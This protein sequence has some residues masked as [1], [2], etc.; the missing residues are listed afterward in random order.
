[1]LLAASFITL[2]IYSFFFF[3]FQLQPMGHLQGQGLYIRSDVLEVSLYRHCSP[4]CQRFC[5]P[6]SLH[7]QRI[8]RAIIM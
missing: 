7:Y 6:L 8:N 5:V 2:K 1:M 3:F 4:V